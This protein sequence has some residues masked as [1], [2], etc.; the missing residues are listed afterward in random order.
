[1][2]KAQ[3]GRGKQQDRVVCTLGLSVSG[4]PRLQATDHR[5]PDRRC[6]GLARLTFKVQPPLEGRLL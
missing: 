1:M 5:S 3:T 4:G 2:V 6:P